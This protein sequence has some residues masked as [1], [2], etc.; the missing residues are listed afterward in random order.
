MATLTPAPDSEIDVMAVALGSEA[1]LTYQSEWWSQHVTEAL[2]VITTPEREVEEKRLKQWVEKYADCF[3]SSYL[4]PDR[5]STLEHQIET[6]DSPPVSEP[7]RSIG[8]EKRTIIN[9]KI[10]EM[11]AHG[12]IRSSR[13]PWAVAVV[14]TRKPKQSVKGIFAID[15]RRLNEFT[16]F[17]AYPIP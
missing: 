11:Q 8:P 6:G 12:I 15:Y 13:S 1:K 10:A 7:P 14:L 3:V 2:K 9:K 17:Y 5:T 4:G 16:K